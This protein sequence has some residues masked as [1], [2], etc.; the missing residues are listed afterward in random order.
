M[1]I[2]HLFKKGKTSNFPRYRGAHLKKAKATTRN[3]TWLCNPFT[4]CPRLLSSSKFDWVGK[5]ERVEAGT[6]AAEGLPGHGI[7]LGVAA[8]VPPAHR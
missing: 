2:H 1:T 6:A 3:F 8:E 5:V 7:V 4:W